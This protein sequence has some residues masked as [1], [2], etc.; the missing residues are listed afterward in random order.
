MRPIILTR[1]RKSIGRPI[2]KGLKQFAANPGKF[3][4]L[5][6][7]IIADRAVDEGAIT[8]IDL[9]K[10]ATIKVEIDYFGPPAK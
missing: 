8:R 2:T 4:G 7:Q 5:A 9:P 3:N 6:V 10:A 1:P